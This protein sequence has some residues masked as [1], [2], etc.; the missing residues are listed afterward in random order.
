[1]FNSR[2]NKSKK[3]T[4]KVLSLDKEMQKLSDDELKNK[5]NEFKERLK[6]GESLDDILVEAYAVVREADWR[7][8]G[9]KPY[10][11]QVIGA[12][13]IH[14]GDVAEMETGSGKTLTATMPVYLNALEGKGVHVV[15][16][17]EY[18][19]KRDAAGMGEVYRWLGLSIGVNLSGMSPFEKKQAYNCDI[20]YS[21]NSEL[22]FD[23]LRDN[24]VYRLQDKVMRGLHYAVIDEAD[25]V[26]IDESRTPLLIS[27]AAKDNTSGYVRADRAVKQLQEEDY[28]IDAKTKSIY[29]T[30][31]GISKLEKY[32]KCENLYDI[33]NTKLV[34][35]INQALKA[36]YIME[37][38]KDYL[39]A[40]GQV[41]IIDSFTGRV[42]ANRQY[43]EGLHQAIEAKEEVEIKGESQKI[44]SITYQNFFRLYDKLSG[45]T[46]TAKTEEEEFLEIYNMRV[47][48]IPKNKPII[49]RDLPDKIYSSQ[50]AKYEALIAKTLRCHEKGQPVL[51]GTASVETNE[52][53]SS[54]LK[55]AG[56]PHEVLN[57]RNHEREAEIV[58]K[59]GQPYAVTVATNMAGRG[60]DIKLTRQSRSFGG[61]AVLGTEHHESR[62]IDNQLRGR[63]GRQGDVGFSQFYVASDDELIK[64]F[65]SDNVHKF[66]SQIPENVPIESKLMTKAFA[67]AQKQIEGQ[68]YESRKNLIK[69][70]DVLRRQRREIYSERDKILT[71]NNM[72]E[73]TKEKFED[74]YSFEFVRLKNKRKNLEELKETENILNIQGVMQ[75][76]KDAKAVFRRGWLRYEKQ[77]EGLHSADIYAIE[78]DVYLHILDEKWHDHIDAMNSLREGITLRSYAQNDPL[79]QYIR[80]AS[81]A[82]Q[83]M[84]YEIDKEFVSRMSH[85]RI[86]S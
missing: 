79:E 71:E 84:K 62:R 47:I 17:N 64:R 61:L 60:T 26:L 74:V 32:L 14:G 4:K 63:S 53:V 20:T 58:A 48:E 6:N 10:P 35:L 3:L 75:D 33:K 82:Y 50:A 80:E 28:K 34:H 46:G 12:C 30:E 22:G 18:L 13:V 5:T 7:V 69:Y 25:S 11:V 15:T 59:A 24:M 9:E 8:R 19:S 31:S 68:N 67:S 73:K 85:I 43:S 81:A 42:M 57:A 83:Q 86:L 36:N 54:M 38:D 55:E 1:M 77:T 65:A 41:K 51:I 52:L 72:R 78:K 37:K 76:E 39:V 29:L 45:M 49:R 27:G 66:I 16:V 23:Y 40:D 21:T 56:I 70:D 2:L 44:A